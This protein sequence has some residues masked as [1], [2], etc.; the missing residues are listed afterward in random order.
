MSRFLQLPL[1]I[2]NII[3]KYC[4]VVNY[5]ITPYPSGYESYKLAMLRKAIKTGLRER[6]S[7]P[8]LP[9]VSILQVS[10]QLHRETSPILYGQNCWKHPQFYSNCGTEC[11]C[12]IFDIHG[13]FFKNIEMRF[14]WRENN[15]QTNY[16]IL[17]DDSAILDETFPNFEQYSH[18][19][20]VECLH[21]TFSSFEF[22]AAS[23][24]VSHLLFHL[25]SLVI[26]VT[27][28]YCSL[29]CCREPVF[30]KYF[31]DDFM[32]HLVKNILRSN[33]KTVKITGL[34]SDKEKELIYKEWGFMEN[35]TLDRAAMAKL[36]DLDFPVTTPRYYYWGFDDCWGPS[37]RHPC[38]TC[39]DTSDSDEPSVPNLPDG[40]LAINA[41]QKRGR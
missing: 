22:H 7:E 25:D 23:R 37:D 1:E 5:V 14:D 4:L 28:L 17:D 27:R 40:F 3:Y 6:V 26:D 11:V 16:M 36:W 8:E 10:K 29:G 2:R 35:G 20:R 32:E 18:S 21:E 31:Q 15:F 34:R 39:F 9:A 38:V 41:L 13:A 33:I 12:S 30:L 19:E 24:D